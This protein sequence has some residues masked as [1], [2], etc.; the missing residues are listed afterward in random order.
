[1]VIV[2]YAYDRHFADESPLGAVRRVLTAARWPRGLSRAQVD[3]WF[4]ELAPEAELRIAHAAARIGDGEYLRRY[5][6]SLADP[7]KQAALVTLQVL[8]RQYDL[9][10]LSLRREVE[11]SHLQ[12]VRRILS[13][14]P[15]ENT[16]PS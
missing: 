1:M 10:L 12:A 7:R 6:E 8:A 15:V 4:P 5:M 16:L 14:R 11:S 9:V 13:S 2:S 3:H